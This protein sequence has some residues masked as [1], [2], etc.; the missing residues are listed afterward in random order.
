MSPIPRPPLDPDL[1]KAHERFGKQSGLIPQEK[2]AARRKASVLSWEAISRGK[3]DVIS[4]SEV[5]I[6]GPTGP[7]RAS[8]LRSKKHSAQSAENT[9]GLV[10][11]HGGGHVTSDRFHGLNTLFDI[12]ETL[13]VVVIGAEY[14]LAPEHPQPAQVEDSYAALL[15]AHSHATELGFNP[16]KIVTCGGSAGG[17]LTAGVSLLA[18]DRSGPRILGQLLFYPWLSDETTSTSLEQFGHLQPWTKEDNEHALDFALGKDREHAS[19]YT[20]PA[21][22]TD[23]SGLPPTYVDVGEADVFRDQDIEFAN[24]LWKSGVAAEFHV[25]LGAWHAFDTF[26]PEAPVS[27]KAFKARLAWLERLIQNTDGWDSV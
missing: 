26:A 7:L 21:R 19:I 1:T 4:H 22:A 17:N 12:V 14:R 15:W 23:L 9:V 18:R 6:P 27:K 25:W 5:D 3:E 8:I 13:G 10:H 16:S 20:L 11:F 2:L 24:T